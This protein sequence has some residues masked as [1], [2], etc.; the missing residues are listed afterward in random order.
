VD[1]GIVKSFRDLPRRE[2][3]QIFEGLLNTESILVIA[4]VGVLVAFAGL[5]ILYLWNKQ[6]G[7]VVTCSGII[8]IIASISLAI[9]A[10]VLSKQ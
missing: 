10:V 6:F 2:G 7:L 8:I 5:A 1:L 3:L 4:V 9:L